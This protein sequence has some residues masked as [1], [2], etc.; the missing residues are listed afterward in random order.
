MIKTY[1]TSV[2][3]ESF[4][5]NDDVKLWVKRGKDSFGKELSKLRSLMNQYETPIDTEYGFTT[6]GMGNLFTQYSVDGDKKVV[7]RSL[8]NYMIN[9][10]FITIGDDGS[11]QSNFVEWMPHVQSIVDQAKLNPRKYLKCRNNTQ[12]IM[13]FKEALDATEQGGYC[14]TLEKDTP[15]EYFSKELNVPLVLIRIN[16]KIFRIHY[17]KFIDFLKGIE[18]NYDSDNCKWKIVC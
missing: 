7:A 4:N 16:G 2:N 1:N 9:Y 17:D 14:V 15:L 6:T 10:D 11:I 12:L 3:F 8:V 5:I 13:N 18:P